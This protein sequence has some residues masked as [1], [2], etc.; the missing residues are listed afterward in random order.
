[1]RVIEHNHFSRKPASNH[2]P[3][4][5]FPPFSHIR[6]HSCP[7]VVK[8]S[9]NFQRTSSPLAPKRKLQTTSQMVATS[10][11]RNFTT[12]ACLVKSLPIKNSTPSPPRHSRLQSR[13]DCDPKPRVAACRFG[14][15]LGNDPK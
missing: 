3:T 8:H 6:V 12:P 13:R 7:S 11:A 1:M 2:P 15:T 10:Y 9:A 4:P 14:A 5:L